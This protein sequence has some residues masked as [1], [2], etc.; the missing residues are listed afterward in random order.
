MGVKNWRQKASYS[1]KWRQ[2]TAEAKAHYGLFHWRVRQELCIGYFGNCSFISSRLITVLL[3]VIPC[4]L[5]YCLTLK[6]IPSYFLIFA[7][8]KILNR[9]NSLVIS[10]KLTLTE[11]QC[12]KVM[13]SSNYKYHFSLTQSYDSYNFTLN[14]IY[15]CKHQVQHNSFTNSFI[16]VIFHKHNG[17]FIIK[18]SSQSF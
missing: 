10:N 3:K 13:V 11:G 7:S 17:E 18:Y 2:V 14:Y 5:Q 6:S 15:N 1:L 8:R 9:W 12:C 4:P 16:V